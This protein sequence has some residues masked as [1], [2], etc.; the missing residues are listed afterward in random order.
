MPFRYL[1][2][3]ICSKKITKA[4]CEIIV[5]K[6]IVRI[7]VWSIRNLSY[8][9]RS[10]LINS[11]LLSLHRYWAHVFIIPKTVLNEVVKVCRE[12]LWRSQAYTHKSRAVA[13]DSVYWSKSSGGLSFREVM[14][15][16][17]ACLRKYVWAITSKQD[18]MWIK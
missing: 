13:W 1:G 16:N 3:P 11:V 5:E 10:Q 15:W 12:F 2:V 18:N 17:K 6:M 4:Q 8:K 7:K 9:E 14:T